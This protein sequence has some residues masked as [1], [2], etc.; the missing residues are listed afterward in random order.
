MAEYETGDIVV[1]KEA[2]E[3]EPA[4]VV[5]RTDM[6]I[7][8]WTVDNKGTTVLDDNP[9]YDPEE[10]TTL[11]VYESYLDEE[12]PEWRD[13]VP[14]ELYQE[15]MQKDHISWYAFPES[16]LQLPENQENGENTTGD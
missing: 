10:L 6:R 15:V 11:V 14:E 12:W 2:D 1:D 9:D 13:T 8:Q 7:S 5:R 3:K 16:R 4:V